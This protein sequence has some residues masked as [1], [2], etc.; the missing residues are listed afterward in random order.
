VVEVVE[1]IESRE[2]VKGIRV[3]F[4]KFIEVIGVE[5]VVIKIIAIEIIVVEIVAIA[6]T[7][8]NNYHL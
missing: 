2:E 3:E 6:T 8:R 5:I 7:Y 1:D 4:I